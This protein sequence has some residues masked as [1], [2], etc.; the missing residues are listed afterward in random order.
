MSLDNLIFPVTL[1]FVLMLYVPPLLLN[2]SSQKSKYCSKMFMIF[3]NSSLCFL[4]GRYLLCFLI[5]TLDLDWKMGGSKYATPCCKFVTGLHIWWQF[6]TFWSVL[7]EDQGSA[8]RCCSPAKSLRRNDRF[9]EE[10]KE[11]VDPEQRL[12]VNCYLTRLD[13]TKTV[14]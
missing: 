12:R 9:K 6:W 4:S 3:I 8:R 10:S 2:S 5:L 14:Q 7:R 1:D 13:R 11:A